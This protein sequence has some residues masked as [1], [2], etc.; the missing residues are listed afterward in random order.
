MARLHDAYVCM[1]VC[2]CMYVRARVPEERDARTEEDEDEERKR[3]GKGH[4]FIIGEACRGHRSNSQRPRER[5]REKQMGRKIWR[6]GREKVSER[7]RIMRKE[8]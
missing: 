4:R 5:E 8:T 3:T 7:G 2:I 1:Y 6:T